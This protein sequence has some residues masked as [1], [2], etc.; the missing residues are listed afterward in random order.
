MAVVCG[1]GG[2]AVAASLLPAR[3]W[4]QAVVAWTEGFGVWAA[5]VFALPYVLLATAAV[6][7]TP[8]TVAAGLLFGAVAGGVIAL[9]GGGMGAAV[10]S[11]LMSR[12]WLGEQFR[13]RSSCHRRRGAFL[14]AV[15]D[16]G[17]KVILLT[18]RFGGGR[19]NRKLGRPVVPASE[20]GCC[21]SEGL[22]KSD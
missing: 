21:K 19:W 9:G 16:D 2:V 5:L 4:V 10:L 8:L 3:D 15:E 6:P 20:E 12:Y 11:F 18:H 1:L 7:T 13:R 14:E 17:W 22:S